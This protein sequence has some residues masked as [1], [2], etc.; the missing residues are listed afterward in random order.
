MVIVKYI[1]AIL[2]LALVIIMP[3]YLA[4]K[5]EQDKTNTTR[6]RCASWLLGWTVIAWLWSLFRSTVK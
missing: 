3:S 4:G 1:I 5:T 6:I 2:L